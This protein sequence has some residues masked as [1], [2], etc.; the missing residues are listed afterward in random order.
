MPNRNKATGN[1]RELRA[2]K[3]MRTKG[4]PKARRR[5]A[6]RRLDEGD[7]ENTGLVTWQVKRL[8]NGASRNLIRKWL[9]EAQ[10]QK[11]NAGTDFG[12]LLYVQEFKPVNQWSV[13]ARLVDVI[14]LTTKYTGIVLPTDGKIVRLD[15]EDMLD[16]LYNAGYAEEKTSDN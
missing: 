13:Y 5:L 15:F 2:A 3:F 14:Q 4:W 8:K 6:G 12:F 1:D 11:K 10:N 9:Q 7:L 16:L